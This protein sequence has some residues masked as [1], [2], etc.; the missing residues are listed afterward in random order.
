[1]HDISHYSSDHSGWNLFS[2]LAICNQWE[3]THDTQLY[4]R[5]IVLLHPSIH[6]L[7]LV[8]A[9]H[10]LL[11]DSESQDNYANPRLAS[12]ISSSAA[13]LS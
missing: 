8:F 7:N 6:H 2:N 5:L 11:P 4:S 12:G 9:L 1:M 13:A 3:T 10:L